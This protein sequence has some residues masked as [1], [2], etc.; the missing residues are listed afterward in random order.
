MPERGTLTPGGAALVESS[1]SSEY[2]SEH[3]YTKNK[4][5]GKAASHAAAVA[6]PQ[7]RPTV[8]TEQLPSALPG[9]FLLCRK[10]SRHCCLLSHIHSGTLLASNQRKHTHN[11]KLPISQVS[12]HKL[13]IIHANKRRTTTVTTPP[14]QP[15][16]LLQPS[17]PFLQGAA[18]S[19]STTSCTTP[20]SLHKS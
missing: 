13:S 4:V 17:P 8:P 7:M 15:P 6:A 5:A 16:A 14:T 20:S 9:D 2:I 3:S 19:R 11:P 1:L 12:F 10:M 18:P